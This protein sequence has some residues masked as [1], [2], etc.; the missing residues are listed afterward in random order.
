[1]CFPGKTPC[2]PM[3]EQHQVPHLAT[4]S[5]AVDSPSHQDSAA[6]CAGSYSY[7]SPYIFWFEV[8]RLGDPP[9]TPPNVLGRFSFPIFLHVYGLT[10]K[11]VCIGART[12]S[13]F[14]TLR[15]QLSHLLRLWLTRGTHDSISRYPSTMAP[16]WTLSQPPVWGTSTLRGSAPIC[17][18]VHLYV[19]HSL[20]HLRHPSLPARL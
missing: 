20:M 13:S 8:L 11:D 18:G 7:S 14:I 9:K 12:G 4:M 2:T 16:R 3:H 17:I 19:L 6:V 5:G 15:G 10:A 1:M